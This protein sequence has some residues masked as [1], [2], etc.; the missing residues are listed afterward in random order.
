MKKTIITVV[1][2][3]KVGILY[4]ICRFLNENNIN[5]LDVSQTI[6]D[7]FFNMMMIV[8]ISKSTKDF[9]KLEEEFSKTASDIG[10]KALMQKEEIFDFMH[11]I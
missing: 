3:D 6:V 11:R 1:G 8:D 10:V 7:G 5:I 2:K 9:Q 4:Q